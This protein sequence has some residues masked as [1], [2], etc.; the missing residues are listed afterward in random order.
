MNSMAENT[1]LVPV[2]GKEYK[3]FLVEVDD[4]DRERVIAGRVETVEINMEQD[5]ADVHSEYNV[6]PVASFEVSRSATLTL[7]LK[8]DENGNLFRIENFAEEEIDDFEYTTED[9]RRRVE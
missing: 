3:L 2:Q 4:H 8:Q 7:R 1:N 6:F 5:W 9:A